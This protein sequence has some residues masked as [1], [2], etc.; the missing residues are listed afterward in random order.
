MAI[1]RTLALAG[2]S[3]VV[4]ILTSLLATVVD[5]N[6]SLAPLYPSP[7]VL[8]QPG[9][10]DNRLCSRFVASG[11]QTRQSLMSITKQSP[12]VAASRRLA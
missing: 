12:P 11:R 4:A 3:F 10:S 9:V 7:R 1:A 8:L 2:T 6:K 5:G